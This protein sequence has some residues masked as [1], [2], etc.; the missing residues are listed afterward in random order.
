MSIFD[1]LP[2]LDESMRAAIVRSLIYIGVIISI[3][4]LARQSGLITPD[5]PVTV[6]MEMPSTILIPGDT[7]PISVPVTVR[8][9]NNTSAVTNL[10]APTT[11]H[12][13][14]WFITTTGGEFIQSEG[15]ANCVAAVI[16]ATLPA[17]EV[18]EEE[19]ELAF[20]SGRLRGGVEYLLMFRFW[21]QDGRAKF[22]AE[23]E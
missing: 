16:T 15:E 9:K 7:G 22:T 21:G 4:Y 12:I 13:F 11:C 14:R 5:E 2:K 20:D 8:L 19:M 10:E 23:M 18:Y 17:G 6:E 3:A 1:R